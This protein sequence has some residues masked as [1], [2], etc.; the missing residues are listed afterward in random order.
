MLIS[1]LPEAATGTLTAHRVDPQRILRAIA[2]STAIETGQPSQEI[3]R[4]LQ[5]DRTFQSLELASPA[6]PT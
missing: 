2:S 3:E 6:L 4:Q 1:T 5:T